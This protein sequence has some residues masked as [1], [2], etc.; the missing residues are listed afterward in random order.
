MIG[1]LTRFSASCVIKSK[2]KEVI[3]KKIFQISISIFGSPKKFLV[4]NRGEFNNHEFISL[5]KNVNIHIFI[6]AAEAPWRNGLVE[7]DNAILGYTVAKTID[8]VKCDL[9]LA[10]ALV[11]TTKNSF[12]NING[13]SPYQMVSGENPNFAVSFN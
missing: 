6:T 1:H 12:E 7:R 10:L 2:C 13:F 3:V 9:E 5:C 8:D 11:A 4:D